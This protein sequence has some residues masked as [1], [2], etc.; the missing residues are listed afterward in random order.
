MQLRNLHHRIRSPRLKI[1]ALHLL[2]PRPRFLP[3]M[4]ALILLL[5]SYLLTYNLPHILHLGPKHIIPRTHHHRLTPHPPKESPHILL[6]HTPMNLR[7]PLPRP[8]VITDPTL[9]E[10]QIISDAITC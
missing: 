6:K 2:N 3:Q 1:P 10:F 5:T 7:P 9:P 8:D 4:S